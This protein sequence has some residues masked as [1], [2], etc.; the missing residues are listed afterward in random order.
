MSNFIFT[1]NPTELTAV[2]T[3][4]GDFSHYHNT[5]SV[6]IEFFRAINANLAANPSFSRRVMR[7]TAGFPK[8]NAEKNETTCRFMLNAVTYVPS[9]ELK[10]SND[11]AALVKEMG[12]FMTEDFARIE[13]KFR[14][15]ISRFIDKDGDGI[16]SYDMHHELITRV[17]NATSAD[18]RDLMRK[19]CNQFLKNFLKSNGYKPVGAYRH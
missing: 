14:A 7:Y 6:I 11:H 8:Y 4:P 18:D 19:T 2:L 15:L 13:K 9:P 16:S 12:H 5:D 1:V 17:E 3:L 10:N